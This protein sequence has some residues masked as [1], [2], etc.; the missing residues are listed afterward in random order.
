MSPW[1]APGRTVKVACGRRAARPVAVGHRHHLVGVAVQQVDRGGHGREVHVPRTSPRQVVAGEAVGRVQGAAEVGEE[2]RR[3]R[4]G[5]R[6]S[7]ARW[8]AG[9]PPSRPGTRPGR[10]AAGGRRTHGPRPRA[11]PARVPP[12][13]GPARLRPRPATPGRV[14][15]PRSRG[16]TAAT[17]GAERPERRPAQEVGQLDDLTPHR[18]QARRRRGRG[19]VPRPVTRRPGV[20]RDSGRH[21]R[22][23]HLRRP[24]SACPAGT[25]PAH[26][27]GRRGRRT[28]GPA[29][30]AGEPR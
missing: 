28:R 21:R 13:S 14:R 15:P 26:R 27:P 11:P 7:S 10:A 5:G 4:P 17:R 12:R 18:G 30:S 20:R 22:A 3:P 9:R 23:A 16:R 29:R 1:P 25:P 2:G 19:A 8:A 6:R 24:C